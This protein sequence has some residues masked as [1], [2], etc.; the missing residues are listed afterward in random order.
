VTYGDA[1]LLQPGAYGAGEFEGAR[2]VA[3]Q[4]ERIS[5]NGY[6]LAGDSL[7]TTIPR[8]RSRLRDD[9]VDGLEQRAWQI[10]RA[11]RAIRLVA[12]ISERLAR[13]R[14]A[15]PFTSLDQ[16]GTGQAD[17]DQIA[18]ETENGARDGANTI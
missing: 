7:N 15:N 4:T 14:Q 10:A 12:P 8:K 2:R 6:S 11:Q 18:V 16:R 9:G 3:V 5:I 17:Q 1:R 13:H